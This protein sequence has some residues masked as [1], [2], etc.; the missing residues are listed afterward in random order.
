ME[1]IDQKDLVRLSN[2]LGKASV[3]QYNNP[4]TSID[5]PEQLEPLGDYFSHSLLSLSACGELDQLTREQIKRLEFYETINFFS[6]NIHGE[7]E[8]LSGMSLK[9]YNDFPSEVT[10]YLH[11]FVDEENKHMLWF[12]T[13]CQ[14]YA[15]KVYQDK[16]IY[17]P[18]EYVEGE[19]DFLFFT[20]IVIFEEIVDHYNREMAKDT[21]LHPIVRQIHRQH[22]IDESRHLSFGREVSRQLYHRYFLESD[23]EQRKKISDYLGHY[24]TSTW[25]EYYNPEVYIDTG[26]DNPFDLVEK[27][28][29]HPNSILFRQEISSKLIEFLYQS[30]ILLEKP[31]LV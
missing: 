8:L 29:S 26:L 25:R 31:E 28:W 18:R 3:N 16:K 22:H 27:A 15:G 7:K 13:F 14:K 10:D 19:K 5:W 23:L 20:K 12:G 2:R 11:H 21:R 24:I 1:P 4:Y 30:Q 9:L 6:I 17:F